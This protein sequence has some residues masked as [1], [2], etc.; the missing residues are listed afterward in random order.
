MVTVV[1]GADSGGQGPCGL[2]WHRGV[3][4]VELGQLEERLRIERTHTSI[5]RR[6]YSYMPRI[7]VSVTM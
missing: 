7:S 2:F 3:F 1:V 5:T 4:G 6:Q